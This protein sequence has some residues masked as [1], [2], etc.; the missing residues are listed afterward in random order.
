MLGPHN[1][2]LERKNSDLLASPLILTAFA[3]CFFVAVA[4]VAVL[5]T[6]KRGSQV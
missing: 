5:M 6:T 3:A 1:V 4:I 2:P